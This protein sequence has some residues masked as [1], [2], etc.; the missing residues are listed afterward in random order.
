[1]SR[2]HAGIEGAYRR[3]V[4]GRRRHATRKLRD[5]IVLPQPGRTAVEERL[6]GARRASNLGERA[7][8]AR[9][10]GNERGGRGMDEQHCRIGKDKAVGMN[11][12]IGA[13]GQF[14][15]PICDHNRLANP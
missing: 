8:Y 1:M 11:I 2:I 12:E 10:E 14:S 13:A 3:Y 9:R 5:P 7:G 4:P 6:D 15:K